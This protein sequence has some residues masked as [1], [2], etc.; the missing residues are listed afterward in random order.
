L[1][2]ARSSKRSDPSSFFTNGCSALTSSTGLTSGALGHRL[3]RCAV[4]V[5]QVVQG[6][7]VHAIDHAKS[8]LGVWHYFMNR[9][10]TT[11]LP[12]QLHILLRLL[13][14][15]D[16]AGQQALHHTSSKDNMSTNN[17]TNKD[18]ISGAPGSH[19]VGTGTGA[20]GGAVAGAA[21]GSVAG[22][23]G[24]VAGAV[25]GAIAGGLAGKEVAENLNPTQGG[26]PSEHKLGT[27][28]GA[29]GGVL[30]GA[31]VGGAMGGPIGAIAGAAIGAAAG[32][33]AGHG[34]AEVVN[35][36]TDDDLA[37]HNLASGTGTGAGAVAGATIGAVGGPVGM[38]AGA[39]IGAVAGNM[40][41]KG[42]GQLVNPVAE[43]A[44]W[45]DNYRTTPG[46]VEG[47]TYDDYAP[48]FRAGY[49]AHPGARGSSFENHEER[50]RSDW[51][52]TKGASRLQWEEAKHAT[53]SA[54][55]RVER[56]LPG[57]ADGDGR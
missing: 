21:I 6:P 8:A 37:N 44:H 4:E 7:L 13:R 55:H 19:P 14:Q 12:R 39:A 30:T 10:S 42:A 36:K 43:D 17:P 18:P 9:F 22:P 48:A 29:T 38:A 3:Q 28:V 24:T 25:V 57:D 26:A 5:V 52:R 53:R 27:G 47:H 35:P 51:E 23:I 11:R 2:S 31:A 33:S 34:A 56:A 45:R 40:M 16:G 15:T 49:E 32:G 46:Y 20:A 41:G 1:W 54:W 50:M